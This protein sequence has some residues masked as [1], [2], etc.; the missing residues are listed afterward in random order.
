MSDCRR[1]EKEAKQGRQKN[2]ATETYS[3]TW[4][5]A[6]GDTDARIT[7]QRLSK[8]EQGEEAFIFTLTPL[9]S[10]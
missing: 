5:E 4:A 9:I 8:P 2:Q 7:P 6:L 3:K 10:F 1:R